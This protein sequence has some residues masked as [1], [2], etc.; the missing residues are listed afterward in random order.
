V[1]GKLIQQIKAIFRR[2]PREFI[3][4]PVTHRLSPHPTLPQGMM[5]AIAPAYEEVLA[6]EQEGKEEK[7]PPGPPS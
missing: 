6:K 7:A 4:E 5:E 1:W 3:F 2:E